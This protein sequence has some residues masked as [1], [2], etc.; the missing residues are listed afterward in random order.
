MF[1]VLDTYVAPAMP[2]PASK[3][4]IV[5][6]PCDV[7]IN[8][9]DPNFAKHRGVNGFGQLSLATKPQFAALGSVPL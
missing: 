7:V 5:I 2:R 1:L 4:D 6:T 9:S 8:N 3:L